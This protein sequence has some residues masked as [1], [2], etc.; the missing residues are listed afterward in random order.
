MRGV[1]PSSLTNLQVQTAEKVLNA[2]LDAYQAEEVTKSLS[3][4]LTFRRP[5]ILQVGGLAGEASRWKAHRDRSLSE[6]ALPFQD[7]D[8]YEWMQSPSFTRGLKLRNFL[9][10]AISDGL[11]GEEFPSTFNFSLASK[12][13]AHDINA[14]SFISILVHGATA[15]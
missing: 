14:A 12:K 3:K 4:L 6:G 15:L 1:K 11:G 13:V 8:F 5:G 10:D 9:P 2:L 7:P